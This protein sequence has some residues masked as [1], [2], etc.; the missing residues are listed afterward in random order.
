MNLQNQPL[1]SVIIPIYNVDKY[2]ARCLDSLLHQT[3]HNL[4][5][6][7]VNDGSTDT[8][9][10]ICDQYAKRDPRFH[11]IHQKNQGVSAA[12]NAGLD[13]M[14]GEFFTFADPD[15]W[16]SRE[17]IEQYIKTF[18]KTK[19]DLVWSKFV[20]I[21]EDGTQQTAS[22][23]PTSSCT[24][25]DDLLYNNLL[26]MAGGIWN[27][28]YHKKLATYCR[29]HTS[30][31]CAEDLVFLCEIFLLT[32][33]TTFIPQIT[34]FYYQQK[35]SA[36]HTRLTK[37]HRMPETLK[38]LEYA[39]TICEQN[40]LKKSLPIVKSLLIHEIVISAAAIAVYDK[41]NEF[42]SLYLFLHSKLKKQRRELFNTPTPLLSR[43]FGVPFLICPLVVAT[44]C[45]LPGISRCLYCLLNNRLNQ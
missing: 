16:L 1:V 21:Y 17:A 27:K 22:T 40:N 33:K 30:F 23:T 28:C 44:C 9:P 19:V 35:Q 6:I 29:F 42:R 25:P 3:Y 8:C 34:Y 31:S 26:Y 14:H 45:R 36:S 18:Q 20:K 5:I 38:A 2:L 7:L 4:E 37:T 32:P 11:V 10:Q 41:K 13:Y 15:D 43:I 39:N 12:R 24:T